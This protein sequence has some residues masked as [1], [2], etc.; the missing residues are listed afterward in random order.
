MGFML[1]LRLIGGCFVEELGLEVCF[2]QPDGALFSYLRCSS[3]CN[4]CSGSAPL[5]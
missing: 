4:P 3:F 5:A 2:G 1:M